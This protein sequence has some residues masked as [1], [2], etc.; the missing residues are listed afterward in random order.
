MGS[1]R[2][3]ILGV[4]GALVCAAALGPLAA[5]AAEPVKPDPLREECEYGIAL[6]LSGRSTAAESVFTSLLSHAP[7]DPRALANL[8]NV[9]LLRGEADVALVLYERAL[10]R[11]STDAGVQLNRAVALMSLDRED[12]ARATAQKA[13]RAAGGTK[14]AED[15]LGMTGEGSGAASGRS[16]EM[17]ARVSVLAPGKAAARPP[18]TR[19]EVRSLLSSTSAPASA[20]PTPPASSSPAP[21]GGKR[22][23]DALDTGPSLYWKR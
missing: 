14:G 11:D 19:E 15:L 20:S 7:G 21:R 12:E 3:W 23:A 8:G 5:R 18:V 13:V 2:T 4:A 6:A 1:C 22:A 16:S 17:S 10:R 9:Y